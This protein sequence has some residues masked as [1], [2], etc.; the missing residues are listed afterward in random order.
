MEYTNKFTD[1][2][3][4]NNQDLTSPVFRVNRYVL[5]INR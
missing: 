1:M 2:K 4:N 5:D 3:K